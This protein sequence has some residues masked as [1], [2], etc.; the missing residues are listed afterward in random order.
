M[1]T[2]AIYTR[3]TQVQNRCGVPAVRGGD[4]HRVTHLTEKLSAIDIYGQR[5]PHFSPMESTLL[6][7]S[8]TIQSRLHAYK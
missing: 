3:H 2:V 1:E 7:L 6:G 8:T 5:E 4:A